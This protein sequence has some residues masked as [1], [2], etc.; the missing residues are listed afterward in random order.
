MTI[1]D[2]QANRITELVQCLQRES[3]EAETALNQITEYEKL[4]DSLAYKLDTSRHLTIK[5][6]EEI[7][8]LLDGSCPPTKAQVIV[9]DEDT[10]PTRI[11]HSTRKTW[12]DFS[13]AES[14]TDH[15]D[16]TYVSRSYL[17]HM[18]NAG[19]SR[20][21]R[22]LDRLIENGV[23]IA[24]GGGKGH[25]DGPLR[26]AARVLVALPTD[27]IP[28]DETPKVGVSGPPNAVLGAAWK[29]GNKIE[30]YRARKT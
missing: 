10:I 25:A 26:Y 24:R 20:V 30:V 3:R 9:S 4:I 1:S 16:S 29:R 8:A 14:L 15:L 18:F 13:L 11:A 23:A 7:R 2:D 5:C 17:C 28:V 21:Q 22:A 12:D 19:Q 6:Q 27:D